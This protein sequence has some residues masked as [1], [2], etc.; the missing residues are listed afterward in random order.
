MKILIYSIIA[1]ATGLIVYNGTFIN[2]SHITAS[3]NGTAFIG[4]LASV[5]VVLLMSVL[6]VSKRIEKKYKNPN[7]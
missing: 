6:L 2:W 1:I 5:C 7:I 3:S 4:I